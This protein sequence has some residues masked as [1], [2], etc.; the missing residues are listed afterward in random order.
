L[1]LGASGCGSC[2]TRGQE[3]VEFREA[4]PT[5]DGLYYET[6]EPFG[7]YL[8]FPPGRTFDLI[9]GLIGTPSTVTSYIAF[10]RTIEQGDEGNT[11]NYAE[12]AGNQV[13]VECQDVERV[14]VR[15][16]TCAELY[17]RVVL[18]ANPNLSQEDRPCP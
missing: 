16:D 15:N 8:H 18:E 7:E 3:P 14:R 5:D 17:L 6:S 10:K 12:S 13:V 4:E 1:L 2:K 11:G 9:H